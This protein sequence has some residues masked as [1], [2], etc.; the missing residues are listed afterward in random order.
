MREFRRPTGPPPLV[1]TRP[2]GAITS[3]GC[4]TVSKRRSSCFRGGLGCDWRG[5]PKGAFARGEETGLDDP[6]S[7]TAT[8][9]PGSDRRV[10]QRP[11]ERTPVAVPALVLLQHWCFSGLGASRFSP[12]ERRP[13]T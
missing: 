8:I 7:L 5:A 3:A 13:C 12:V 4:I 9:S 10:R 6:K 1:L 2:S 11:Q